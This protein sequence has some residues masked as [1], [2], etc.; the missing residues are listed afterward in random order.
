MD[1]GKN[2][3]MKNHTRTFFMVS[4]WSVFMASILA[5]VGVQAP[6]AAEAPQ[7]NAA[8]QKIDA[9]IQF[10]AGLVRL[11]FPD[12]AEKVMNRL[13][14]EY[15]EAKARAAAIKIQSLTAR[16]KFDEAEK[17][18]KEMPPDSIETLSMMLALG[19]AYYAWNKLGNA[20]QCYES[21]FKKYPNGPPKELAKLYSESA[22]Q[23]AQMLSLK[24]DN[25][26]ALEAYRYV[27]MGQPDADTER[28]IKAEMAEFL[29]KVGQ[30]A[31]PAERKALFAE[32][33]KLCTEIQWKGTDLFFGKTVVILA[34]M[35][36]VEGDPTGAVKVI[37]DYLPMLAQIENF[38]KEE[39]IS[40]KF[41]PM[42]ECRF[43]L[44]TVAEDEGRKMVENPAQLDAGKKKLAEA[45][46]HY[47]TIFMKYY[48][49]SWAP[50]AGKKAEGIVA[51][52]ES[53]KITVKKPNLDMTQLME[54]Q[55][56]EAKS[57]FSENNFSAAAEKYL[58]VLSMFPEQPR[59]VGALQDLATCYIQEGGSEPFAKAVTQYLAQRFAGNK[60]VATEA[61]NALLNIAGIY[62]GQGNQ[63][64]VSD[65]YQ[66]FIDR[67]KDHEKVPLVIYRFGDF[68]FQEKKYAEALIYYN[69]LIA[70]YPKARQYSD[71][72]SRAAQCATSLGSHSNACE[73]LTK[74]L[75]EL[76][77]GAD[78]VA[79]TLRLGEAYRANDQ[80]VQAINEYVRVVKY[81][82]EEANL[83]SRTP[84]DVSRNRK[85]VEMA[86]Y[87]KSVCYTRLKKP[88]DRI[89]MFQ[90]K[91]IE[92]FEQL[93]KDYPKSDLAPQAL[94]VMG[95]LLYIQNKPTEANSAYERLK[96][97]FPTSD[98]ASNIVF[99]RGDSL[100]KM[101]RKDEAV[102]VFNE[103]F[104][105]AKAY[106]PQQFMKVGGTMAEAKEYQTAIKAFELARQGTDSN[107]WQL[108][109]LGLG[110]SYASAS[111]YLAAIPPMEELLTKF[112]KSRAI[113]NAYFILS[114][115]YAQ[116]AGQ[117]ADEVKKREFFN[118]G[119][120]YLNKARRL[121][122]PDMRPQ[123]DLKVA[124]IQ[125]LQGKTDDA[126]ASYMRLLLT[127]D[128][129]K[130]SVRPFVEEAFV[131]V[132]PLLIEKKSFQDVIDNC[133][134][135][136]TTFQQGTYLKQAREWRSQMQM[137]GFKGAGVVAEEPPAAEAAA[138]PS[139]VP[140]P[141][142]APAAPPEE[143][144]GTAAPVAP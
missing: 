69:R 114:E 78:K 115:A 52:L 104:D 58:E 64:R 86:L 112:P 129:N 100:L 132:Q 19:D 135:Y 79:A 74:Y 59:S 142:S 123:A 53:K 117:E 35:K 31:P 7:A 10:A 40:L 105:N 29:L 22:Y 134:N 136:V 140:A 27:L 68:K 33:T 38:L 39:K 4:L 89:P 99:V 125:L 126:I 144:A 49:S 137:K 107:T 37:S 94:S 138:A 128:L 26:G 43:L 2:F 131:K 95:T 56:V 13:I 84:E 119:I 42:A 96:R 6:P 88:E 121:M 14:A 113:L 12:Y 108:A 3:V 76:S 127:A 66:D 48:A 106:T 70:D 54:A 120:S 34:H 109:T 98:Q 61:G 36:L 17:L 45:L 47:Y 21:F 1:W 82:T 63:A 62:E 72:L 130:T 55:F 91:A 102:K 46:T 81:A 25:K 110:E 97:D 116:K 57:L 141:A 111:N 85:L 28:Q 83:Y 51:F 133:E 8:D 80:N 30:D 118:K 73:Y 5:V 44:G 71:A 93:V 15:P 18:I 87:F 75:A 41:S 77:P 50:E 122:D 60:R 32:A 139:A 67:F 11:G 9:D 124:A 103:M 23:F 92:G 101:G 90:S 16:G 24:G 143:G 65:I 20:K